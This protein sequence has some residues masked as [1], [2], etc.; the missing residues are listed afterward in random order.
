MFSAP[1]AVRVL[2]SRT[3]VP[4]K[5]T[6]CKASKPCGWLASRWTNPRRLDQRRAAGAHHRQLLADRNRLA[7][8]DAVQ[9]RGQQTSRFGSPG[10]AVYGYNVKLIDEATGEELT[11]PQ[12]KGVLA[13]E[14]PLPRLPANRVAR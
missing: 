7:H 2:K 10:K 3:R 6:T 13:I 12:P 5:N 14:G 4:E 1:T 9:R 8:P 11:T